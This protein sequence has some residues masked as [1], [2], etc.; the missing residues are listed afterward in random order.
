MFSRLGLNEVPLYP[1]AIRLI[2]DM[3]ESGWVQNTKQQREGVGVRL[4]NAQQRLDVVQA[5]VAAQRAS[6]ESSA[7]ERVEHEAQ[8]A[9]RNVSTAAVVAAARAARDEVCA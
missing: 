9:E 8:L 2:N 5:A 4:F 1:A 6:L 3:D 7:T